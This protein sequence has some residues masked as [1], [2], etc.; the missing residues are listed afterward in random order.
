MSTTTT[1]TATRVTHHAIAAEASNPTISQATEASHLSI[2]PAG[3]PPLS[4]SLWKSRPFMVLLISSLLLTIGNK[5]YEI[6]LP[7]MMYEMTHSSVSMTNMRTAELLPNLLFAVFI[8][9]LVDRVNKKRWVLWMIGAQAVL[10]FILVYLFRANIQTLWFY[11]IVGFLLMTFNYGF[12]NAQM[13]LTKLTVPSDQL[14]SANARFTFV[15][16]FVG[17]MGPALSAAILLLANLSDGFVVTAVLYLICMGLLSRLTVAEPVAATAPV[18]S[19]TARS[20]DS[21]LLTPTASPA[22]PTPQTVKEKASFWT[23]LAEGWTAFRT[24]RNLWMLSLFTVFL[25]CTF[26]VV[27]TAVIFFATDE[28]ALSASTVAAVLSASGVGGLLGSI[29]MHRLR[30]RLGLGKVYGLSAAIHAL[31]YLGLCLTSNLVVLVVSLFVIGFA[32]SLYVTSSYTFRHEQT[33]TH[34]MGRISGITGCLYRVGMPVVMYAAGYMMMW[35][36][37]GSIFVSAVVWNLVVFAVYV[38]TGLWK[39]R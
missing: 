22:D 36:G 6:I 13:S 29:L 18:H 35:W 25:N 34:L 39:I 24:N 21:A 1:T 3:H 23:E 4:P 33:P 12:F 15:E 27:T 17:I 20:T 14:T 8:G 7:L 19:A 28:L 38:R 9:V 11:Y 10:L 37:T 5:I 26:T 2:T 16:T 30:V 31:G 32:S